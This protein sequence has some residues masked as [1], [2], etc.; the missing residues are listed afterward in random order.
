MERGCAPPHGHCGLHRNVGPV[1]LNIEGY[2]NGTHIPRLSNLWEHQAGYRRNGNTGERIAD[3]QDGWIVVA[4]RGADPFIYCEGKILFAHHG[5]GSWQPGE[6][7]S[8]LNTMAACMATLGAVI[9]EAGD[10]FTDEDC[11]IRDEH[12]DEAISRLAKILGSKLE[13]ES[14]VGDAGWG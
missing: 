9:K 3:W 14:V 7:Y 13:A 10:D 5:T 4:D 1:D 12:R 8:D 2:G 6:I 11:R